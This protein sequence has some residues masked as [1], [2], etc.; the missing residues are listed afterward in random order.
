MVPNLCMALQNVA[1]ANDLTKIWR[2][3]GF[4]SYEK[5][6]IQFHIFFMKHVKF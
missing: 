5:K 2:L 4:L 3:L 1:S 6:K